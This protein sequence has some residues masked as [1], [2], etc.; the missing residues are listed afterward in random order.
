[1]PSGQFL[2]QEIKHGIVIPKL[3]PPAPSPADLISYLW[4]QSSWSS[5]PSSSSR[6][7]EHRRVIAVAQNLPERRLRP[8]PGRNL[9]GDSS[10]TLAP[11]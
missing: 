5:S 8:L 4:K 3:L 10:E 1:M 6:R 7:A 9:A 11:L 2:S